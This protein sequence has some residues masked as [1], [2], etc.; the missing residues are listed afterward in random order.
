MK[1][2]VLLLI[3]F[4]LLA[5]ILPSPQAFAVNINNHKIDRLFDAPDG[6]SNV[7]Y[8]VPIDI[9]L[10]DISDDANWYK[11][12]LKFSIGPA[13]FNIVGWAYIP[14][15]DFLIEREAKKGLAATSK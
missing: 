5:G 7:I 10:L 2:A 8:N 12:Q 11:V 4:A 6:K 3:I 14:I 9:R 1:K 15:G 13:H